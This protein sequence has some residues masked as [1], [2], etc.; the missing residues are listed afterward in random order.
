MA[1]TSHGHHIPRS[2]FEGRAPEAII[3]CGGFH[4]CLAC[5]KERAAHDGKFNE[6]IK[7]GFPDEELEA[8]LAE[9]EDI[10]RR[11]RHIDHSS[12]GLEAIRE[13][14][15]YH[16]PN[17]LTA[18]M[19]QAVRKIFIDGALVLDK[20]LPNGRAKFQAIMELELAC[21]WANKA[22][23]EMSPVVDE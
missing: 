15:G 11:L 8:L 21:M 13:R 22:I 5:I 3:N 1:W 4:N 18:K 20:M 16:K 7:E 12:I 9:D 23:A 19:H 6:P 10:E 2:G 17:V 14:F